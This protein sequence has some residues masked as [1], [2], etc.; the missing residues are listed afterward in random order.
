[1]KI[2]KTTFEKCREYNVVITSAKKETKQHGTFLTIN[3]RNV[4]AENTT[5]NE[6]EAFFKGKAQQDI[7]DYFAK[8]FYNR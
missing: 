5:G 8:Q 6:K 7:V 4:I 2:S 1:M 3:Y